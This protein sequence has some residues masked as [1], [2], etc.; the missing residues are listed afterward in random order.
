MFHSLKQLQKKQSLVR[1]QSI[2]EGTTEQGSAK[3]P[4]DRK[5]VGSEVYIEKNL[6]MIE[7]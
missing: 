3:Y 1:F 6:A 4:G 2:T 5:A 7:L